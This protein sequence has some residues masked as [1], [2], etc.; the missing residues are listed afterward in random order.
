MTAELLCAVDVGTTAVKATC[1]RPDG[2]PVA[3]SYREHVLR[4]PAPDRVEQDPHV[5]EEA[6][7]AAL[8]DVVLGRGDDIAAVAV[9]SARATVVPVDRVGRPLYPFIIWQDRRSLATC[10]RLRHLMGDDEY[11]RITGLRLEPVA[12]GS[13]AVWLREHEPGVHAATWRYWTQ[14]GY[15][16]HRLGAE[17]P[18]TD[19]SMGGYY[20]LIDLETLDWSDIVLAAFGVERA[21]LPK[22]AQ[23]GTLVGEVSVVAAERTG[24]RR[25]TPLVLPGSDAGCCWLGAGMTKASQ[26][27]A[28][29]G[30]AAGIVSYLEAPLRDPEKRLTCLPYALPRTWT[31]EGLLLS[32]GAAYKW[33]RDNLAPLEVEA[34]ARLG[35]DAYELLESQ[36]SRVPAG[37]NGVLVI[38]TFVGAGAPFWEPR[39]RGMVVGLGL[40]HDRATLARA[41]MEGVALELR[42]ALE[43][44]RR[45]GVSITELTLTGGA[46]RSALWNQIHADTHGVPVVT[47]ASPDPTALGAAICAGVGA[48]LFLDLPTGVDAMRRAG[49]RYEPSAERHAR[50]SEM[51]DVYRGILGAFADRDL[52]ARV[53]GLSENSVS[54]R[55]EEP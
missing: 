21:R 16:L 2:T 44:M 28:Y 11:F 46:S 23:A 6:F 52:H 4:F 40:G 24:L 14:Q 34:A 15:F 31:M 18:P 19:Y 9:T 43:E 35:I 5:L 10:E 53:A 41:V 20:G 54:G 8:R 29:V 13:K 22:L 3:T 45:L 42:N 27:A 36:A 47:L 26:V 12:V 55:G 7:D 38:P 50:Y 17:D 37:A 49:R 51:L 32:A 25:R 33:F 39:A 48:R 1:F 30:T